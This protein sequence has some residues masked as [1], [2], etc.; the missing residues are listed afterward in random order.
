MPFILE[1]LVTTLNDDGAAHVAP[2]GPIV[3]AALSHLTLRPFPTSHTLRNLLRSRQG[4]FHVTDN[5]E[6]LARAAVNQ[7][8]LPPCE[9]ARQVAG[10]VLTDAC[11]WYEFE[12]RSVDDREARMRLECAVVHQGRRRD[13]IGFNRAKHAVVE[14]AILASRVGLRPPDQIRAEYDRLRVIVT[15]TAGGQEQRA[16]DF[17]EEYVRQ[18]LGP[19]WPG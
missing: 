18:Q 3:D 6:M 13:F 19:G 17:L 14:A 11:R 15:K 10:A 7:L 1:G 5:V 12:V 4:V 8:E 16:F 9:A 2:M